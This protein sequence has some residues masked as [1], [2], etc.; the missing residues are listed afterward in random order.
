MSAENLAE[1]FVELADT[2]AADFD[3]AEFMHRL[4]HRCV[5][6]LGVDAAGILLADHDGELQVVG[7]SSDRARLVELFELQH[8][9]GPCVECYL[10]SAPVTLASSTGPPH[11]WREFSAVAKEA[12][13][14]AVHALPMRLRDQTVGALNLFTVDEAA[15]AEPTLRVAQ[16]M[17]DVAT[18]GLLQARVIS[19]RELLAGQL[20]NALQSR[21]LIEQA[22][23]VLAERLQIDMD[24]AF[25]ALRRYSRDNNLRLREVADGVITGVIDVAAL[26]TAGAPGPPA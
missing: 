11:R 13:F 5:T 2:L 12:G 22:K 8:R 24:R 23:G 1:T 17:A 10:T 7:A 4:S 9:R 20:Q 25:D 26:R 21:V 15:L 6:A 19:H 18:I 16:A 14:G 3:P